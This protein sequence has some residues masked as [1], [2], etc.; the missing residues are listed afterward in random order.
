MNPVRDYVDYDFRKNNY[1][2]NYTYLF[3]FEEKAGGSLTG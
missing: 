2:S 1:K 3:R